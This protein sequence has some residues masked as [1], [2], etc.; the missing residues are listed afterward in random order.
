MTDSIW[1]S[2]PK[3]F[4][5]WSF[6]EL[7][8]Q[9]QISIYLY[10]NIIY[11]EPSVRSPTFFHNLTLNNFFQIF[12]THTFHSSEVKYFTSLYGHSRKTFSGFEVIPKEFP[13]FWAVVM[14][15]LQWIGRSLSLLGCKE[16]GEGKTT[17]VT[18]QEV[19]KRNGAVFRHNRSK[20]VHSSLRCLAFL[21]LLSAVFTVTRL[22]RLLTA[23]SHL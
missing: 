1:P 21:S 3:I 22:L 8:L 9:N 17:L 6:R 4:T 15:F 7:C 20:G 16:W 23:I 11:K 10:I 12:K 18:P 14:L 19:S 5:I 13:S 2:K